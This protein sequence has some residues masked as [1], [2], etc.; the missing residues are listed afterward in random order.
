VRAID[1]TD[2]TYTVDRTGT[3][4]VGVLAGEIDL[5]SIDALEA[6]I[7][8]IEQEAAEGDDVVLDMSGVTFL[9]SSGLR[10]LVTAND[11][12]DTAGNRLVIR[13][14]SVSVV[15]VLEITGLL[16]TIIVDDE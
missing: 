6:A 3:T 5:A 16:S 4:A 2:L 13:R 1:M 9:D 10:V 11:R 15:R 12:L 14:P 7:G 8:A